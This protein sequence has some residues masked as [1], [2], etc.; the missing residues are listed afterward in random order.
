MRPQ[1]LT[2]SHRVSRNPRCGFELINVAAVGGLL[3]V[4]RRGRR[5][6][7]EER[8]R[9]SNPVCGTIL[10]CFV[11]EFIIGP[12]KPDPLAPRNDDCAAKNASKRNTAVDNAMTPL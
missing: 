3:T 2:V 11:A 6:H 5:R 12:A 9:R 8:L 7:C 1:R 4:M 10:D